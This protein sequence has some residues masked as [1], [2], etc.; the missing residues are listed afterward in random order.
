METG[1]ELIYDCIERKAE[2][3]HFRIILVWYY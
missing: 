2:A 3:I 1:S